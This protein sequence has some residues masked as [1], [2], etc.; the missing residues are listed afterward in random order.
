LVTTTCSWCNKE[1][2]NFLV[3][4][5]PR[6]WIKHR[7]PDH[8][9]MLFCSLLCF[10]AFSGGFAARKPV[11]PVKPVKPIEVEEEKVVVAPAQ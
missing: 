9:D 5:R 7:T 8:I 10:R 4:F 6:G 11:K 2:K 1:E 3:L